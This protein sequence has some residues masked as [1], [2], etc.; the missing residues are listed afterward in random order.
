MVSHLNFEHMSLLVVDDSR[1]MHALL[2]QIVTAMR[3]K[4]ITCCETVAEAREE[5]RRTLPDIVITDWQMEP[6]SGLDFVE[7]IRKSEDSPNPYIPIIL[8]TAYAEAQEVIKARDSGVTEVL[9]KPI[10][11]ETLY[12][13][14]SMLVERPRP[15]VKTEVYFGPDR[16]RHQREYKGE[17]RRKPPEE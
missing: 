12:N 2:R 8:L 16:R 10:S 6:E 7:W 5:M 15:F 14:I 11:V 9:A 4:A 13:R 1:P 3:I 17:D